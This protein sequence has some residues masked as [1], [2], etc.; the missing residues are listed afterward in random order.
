MSSLELWLP[1]EDLNKIKRGNVLAQK[2]VL[3]SLTQNWGVTDS[4]WL[5]EVSQFSLRVWVLI[6]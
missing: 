2:E 1:V 4:W 3:M 6:C 5:L